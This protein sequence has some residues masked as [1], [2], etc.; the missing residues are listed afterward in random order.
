MVSTINEPTTSSVEMAGEQP[1]GSILCR[2]LGT[3]YS[4]STPV[5]SLVMNMMTMCALQ[6]YF[7][8]RCRTLCGIPELEIAGSMDDW[9]SLLAAYGNIKRVLPELSRWYNALDVVFDSILR[10]KS[11]ADSSDGATPVVASE[12]DRMFWSHVFSWYHTYG[13][14]ATSTLYGWATILFPFTKDGRLTIPDKL[15]TCMTDAAATTKAPSG[16]EERGKGEFYGHASL[17]KSIGSV[18]ITVDGAPYEIKAGC[19]GT[20]VDDDQSTGRRVVFPV[21]GYQVEKKQQTPVGQYCYDSE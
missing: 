13:S 8:F 6:Q 2:A 19:L 5:S 18:P 17:Q 20:G 9:Q 12:R 21:Y 7:D 10:M 15:P 1:L 14:G 11:A 16:D 3:S 4:T